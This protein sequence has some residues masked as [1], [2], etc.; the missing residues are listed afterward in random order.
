MGKSDQRMV[1][2]EIVSLALLVAKAKVY[3]P[4]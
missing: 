2:A 3:D 4:E 1:E